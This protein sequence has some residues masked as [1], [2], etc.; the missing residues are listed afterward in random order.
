[1]RNTSYRVAATGA[2]MHPPPV[3]IQRDLTRWT[4]REIPQK[5]ER[6]KVNTGM[7]GAFYVCIVYLSL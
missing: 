2:Q 7:P 3:Q 6:E 5:G 1:M 4:D